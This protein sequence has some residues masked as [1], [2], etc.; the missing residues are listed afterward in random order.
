MK[1]VP[2]K[3]II[4]NV[5]ILIKKKEVKLNTIIKNIFDLIVLSV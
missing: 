4:S 5:I 1:K 2:R 3:Y